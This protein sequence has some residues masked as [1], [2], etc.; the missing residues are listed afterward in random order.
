MTSTSS[1]I[2]RP[3]G[4]S[5]VVTLLAVIAT[6]VLTL[7]AMPS[8]YVLPVAIAVVFMFFAVLNEIAPSL[9][10]PYTLRLDD[11]YAFDPERLIDSHCAV[12]VL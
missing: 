11:A 1:P 4:A 10:V 7:Y 8:A 12:I 3:D 9:P 2:A 5:T 6:A